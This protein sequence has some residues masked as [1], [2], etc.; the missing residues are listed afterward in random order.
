MELLRQ[1]LSNPILISALIGWG[2][3]QFIKIPIDY[4]ISHQWNWGLLRSSGGM[5]SSH[6]TLMVAATLSI[7]LH[8][9]FD[10]ALFGLAVALTMIVTYDAA[11]VRR[12]AGV[13]AEK[14]NKLITELFAGEP[15]S[16]DTLKEVIGHTP[17]QVFAG[18]IL[19]LLVGW[20]TWLLW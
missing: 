4:A 17:R 18:I 10:S 16:E 5:P 12:Q 15:L 2:L 8:V 3:A 7:G 14:I 11:G 1:M 9:G 19:G 20:I 13:Q 6:S